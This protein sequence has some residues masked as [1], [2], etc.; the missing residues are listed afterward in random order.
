MLYNKGNLAGGA[1]AMR[2][3]PLH[4]PWQEDAETLGQLYQR[5]RVI[6]VRTRLHALWLLRQGYSLKHT[7]ALLKVHYVTL[8]QWLAWYRQGGLA[9]LRRHLPGNPH[10]ASAW[11][12]PAQQAALATAASAGQFRTAQQAV[13]WVAAEFGVQ[14]SRWGMYQLLRRLRYKHKVPRPSSERADLAAQEEWK[15]GGA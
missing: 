9:E 13:D 8:Q 10:G 12:N 14:Y 5:E 4:I 15:K 7:S 1:I 3:R 6:V 11:L 2:G